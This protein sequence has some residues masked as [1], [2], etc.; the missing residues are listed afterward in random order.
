MIAFK[1]SRNAARYMRVCKKL[2]RRVTCKIVRG[3]FVIG[4]YA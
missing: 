4:V 1:K 2:G 3:E